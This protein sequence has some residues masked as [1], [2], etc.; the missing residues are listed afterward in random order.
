MTHKYHASRYRANKKFY[1]KEENKEKKRIYMREYS[2]RPNIIEKRLSKR[3]RYLKDYHL[4][5]NI[6]EAKKEYIKAYN[7]RPDVKAKRHEWY[8]QKKIKDNDKLNIVNSE[9]FI[10][11][12]ERRRDET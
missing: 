12:E 2:K 11:Y 9:R 7:A 1:E 6:I 8:L 10:N 3:K 4:Q 5:P